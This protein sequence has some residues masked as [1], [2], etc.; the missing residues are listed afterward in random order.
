[1][2]LLFTTLYIVR[3]YTFLIVIRTF[4]IGILMTFCT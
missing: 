3:P 4:I 1:M 2:Q